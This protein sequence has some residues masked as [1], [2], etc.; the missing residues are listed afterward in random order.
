MFDFLYLHQYDLWGSLGYIRDESFLPG[1]LTLHESV[2]N[3]CL[4]AETTLHSQR[5]LVH[6][7]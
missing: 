2:R 5:F 1:D 3:Q 4:I 7:I 6:V